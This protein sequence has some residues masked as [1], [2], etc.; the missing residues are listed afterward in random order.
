MPN[1]TGLDQFQRKLHEITH[2]VEAIGGD[3]A[4]LR[5]NP[6]D[7]ASI[8]VAI[9][10]MEAAIDAKVA[11]YASNSTVASIVQELKERFRQE[12]VDRAARA[13]LTEPR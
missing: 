11:S 1:V 12:I 8:D 10:Q 4:Q 6:H 2:A 7:P 3:I 9:H 5:F 13:R